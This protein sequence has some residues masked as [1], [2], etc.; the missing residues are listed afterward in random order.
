MKDGWSSTIF[1]IYLNITI[2]YLVTN[3]R[4]LHNDER[5]TLLSCVSIHSIKAYNQAS[6][7]NTNLPSSFPWFLPHESHG[8][9][10]PFLSSPLE[11][12][13]KENHSYTPQSVRMK[14]WRLSAHLQV[15]ADMGR[16]WFGNLNDLERL[17]PLQKDLGEECENIDRI[18]NRSDEYHPGFQGRLWTSFSRADCQSAA[19]RW[20]HDSF[21]HGQ[22][23]NA[24]RKMKVVH[25]HSDIGIS[26][27]QF[28]V[29]IVISEVNLNLALVH[30]RVVGLFED[31]REFLQS[32]WKEKK[33][34]R[35]D[36]QSIDWIKM[37]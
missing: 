18:P 15:S 14:Q 28:A 21:L 9:S 22:L 35:R 32:L 7:C 16:R 24:S 29:H 27:V 36:C 4:K 23:K 17:C 33:D 25:T 8:Q 10:R 2:L 26:E 37:W 30:L 13:R 34:R 31:S 12:E 5:I 3:A 1:E 6:R 19:Q 20:C 11:P